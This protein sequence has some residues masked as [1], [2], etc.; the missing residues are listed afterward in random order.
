MRIGNELGTAHCPSSAL[1]HA[2]SLMTS[3]G[4]TPNGC[5]RRAGRVTRVHKQRHLAT[6]GTR[7][8]YPVAV[9]SRRKMDALIPFDGFAVICRGC[10]QFELSQLAAR[11]R[12]QQR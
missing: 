10:V 8:S 3:R 1:M 12:R 2:V 6:I 5:R 11:R 4:R 7:R 9:E